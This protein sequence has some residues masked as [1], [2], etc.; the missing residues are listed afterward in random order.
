MYPWHKYAK[1]LTIKGIVNMQKILSALALLVTTF[2]FSGKSFA[3]ASGASSKGKS[4]K[5]SNTEADN[6]DEPSEQNN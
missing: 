3:D 2:A 6:E 5:N 1:K 4:A